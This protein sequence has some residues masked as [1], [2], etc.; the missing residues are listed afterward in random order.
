M[1]VKLYNKK[2][3]VASFKRV[4][5]DAIKGSYIDKIELDCELKNAKDVS[6]LLNFLMSAVPCFKK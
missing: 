1:G 4:P 5:N 6:N 2:E 3:L